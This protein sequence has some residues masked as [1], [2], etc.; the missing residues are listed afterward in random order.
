MDYMVHG[1]FQARTLERAAIP[2]SRGSSQ[3]RDRPQVSH[4]AGR[5]FTNQ[6]SPRILEWIAYP[7]SSG[8]SQPRNGT[9]VSCIAGGF[10]TNRGIEEA[11]VSIH[12]GNQT[13]V[14]GMSVEVVMFIHETCHTPREPHSQS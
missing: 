2:L 12:V 14:L 7:F 10:F 4:I 13:Y 6:G 9:G 3:P 1:I 11:Q 8:S 5:F